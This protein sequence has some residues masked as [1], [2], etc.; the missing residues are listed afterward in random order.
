MLLHSRSRRASM[1]PVSNPARW[2]PPAKRACSIFRQRSW[3]TSRPALGRSFGGRVVA[4]PEL[5]PQRL[6]AAR[7]RLLGDRRQ[8]VGA[9]ERVDDVGRF[10]QVGERGVHLLAEDLGRAAGSR[11]RSSSR[12]RRRGRS[13]RNGSPGPGW[14]TSRR[15]PPSGFAAGS[16][17]VRVALVITLT[18]SPPATPGRGPN[19]CPRRPR[20]RPRSARGRA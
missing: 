9:A 2:S 3:T 13:R 18:R 10:G 20:G 16:P 11:T 12:W 14:R 15:S 4:Q 6:G 1:T 17:A 8:V 5:E 19:R 7:D